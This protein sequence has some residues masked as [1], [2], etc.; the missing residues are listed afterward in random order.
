LTCQHA[1]NPEPD[2]MQKY[3]AKCCAQFPPAPPPAPVTCPTLCGL[4]HKQITCE[5]PS[6]TQCPG[7]GSSSASA[8]NETFVV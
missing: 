3:A 4:V 8:A 1:P 5:R 7:C 6:C 2:C